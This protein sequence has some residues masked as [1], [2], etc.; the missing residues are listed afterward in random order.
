M[1]KHTYIHMHS[2]VLF[3]IPM[4]LVKIIKSDNIKFKGGHGEKETHAS[5]SAITQNN[6]EDNLPKSSIIE[7][8]IYILYMGS[9][10]SLII[11]LFL[12]AKYWK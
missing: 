4:R 1:L 10:V 5:G 9:P 11:V 12:I 6:V 3:H 7:N 8:Y 2:E